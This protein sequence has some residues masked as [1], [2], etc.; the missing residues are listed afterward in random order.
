MSLTLRVA[1]ALAFTPDIRFTTY[2]SVPYALHTATVENPSGGEVSYS[3]LSASPPDFADNINF[4]PSDRVV[5]LIAV[6]TT[7]VN[8]SIYIRATT[9]TEQATLV[10]QLAAVDPPAIVAALVNALTVLLTGETG[11]VASLSVSGGAGAYTYAIQPADGNLTVGADGRISLLA[12]QATP[13]TLAATLTAD[14]EHPNT[15]AVALSVTLAVLASPALVNVSGVVLAGYTGPVA[16]VANVLLAS[17]FRLSPATT[18]SLS[19]RTGC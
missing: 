17:D 7:P 19:G 12:A 9:A 3:L 5:N 10:L 18:T 11:V 13:T 1:D 15:P 2:R 4:T 6:Q 14:D 8:A 16:S